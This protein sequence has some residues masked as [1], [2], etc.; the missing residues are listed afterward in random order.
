VRG[1][2][3]RTDTVTD[4]RLVRRNLSSRPIDLHRPPSR[5]RNGLVVGVAVS[6]LITSA[7]SFVPVPLL[8]Y[9]ATNIRRNAHRL[10]IVSQQTSQISDEG[11]SVYF[12]PDVAKQFKVLTCSATSCAAKR[13]A[14]SLDDYATFSAFWERIQ[15]RIPEVQVEETSCLGA[16][17][18]APCVAIEHEEFEGTV[19]ME[20]MDTFEFADRVFHRVLDEQDAD[21][22]WGIVENAIRTMAE[23]VNDD[24]EEI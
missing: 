5:S 3:P 4:M 20:G 17:K 12:D 6:L 7:E 16:C 18:K 14:L 21:R 10:T 1:L 23:Q 11:S 9:D 22:V 15:D 13:K 19:A 2:K 8:F 24:C